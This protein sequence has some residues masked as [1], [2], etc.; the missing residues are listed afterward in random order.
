M[1]FFE[2]KQLMNTEIIHLLNNDV[3]KNKKKNIK[4]KKFKCFH[5]L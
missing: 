4:E 2:L 1:I 3:I 5:F